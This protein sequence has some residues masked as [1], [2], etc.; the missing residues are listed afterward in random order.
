[1]GFDV[2]SGCSQIHQCPYERVRVASTTTGFFFPKKNQAGRME[3]GHTWPCF[4]LEVL[5]LFRTWGVEA[6]HFDGPVQEI[7]M[8][9]A[10]GLQLVDVFFLVGIPTGVYNGI[11]MG[12]GCLLGFRLVYPIIN[13]YTYIHILYIIMTSLIIYNVSWESQSANC[14]RSFWRN[15]SRHLFGALRSPASGSC[16][17]HASNLGYPK[18]DGL[19]KK[20]LRI[21]NIANWKSL[22]F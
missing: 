18:L 16:T 1:M 15:F 7:F 20:N 3:H 6:T 13:I 12:M 8:F 5:K 22:F 10:A 9:I 2:N 21:F 14:C 11:I 4:T 17:G 19:F